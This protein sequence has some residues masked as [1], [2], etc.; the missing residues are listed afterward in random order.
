MTARAAQARRSGGGGSS[1]TTAWRLC[2]C[3]ASTATLLPTAVLA[4][5]I[6]ADATI[7]PT[8]NPSTVVTGDH[9]AAAT[10]VRPHQQVHNATGYPVEQDELDHSKY[11]RSA[12]ARRKEMRGPFFFFLGDESTTRG[13]RMIGV[14]SRNSGPYVLNL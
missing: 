1:S 14:S 2:L 13:S 5:A 12:R 4:A 6:N 9:P 8:D 10:T 3:L 11:N 7:I